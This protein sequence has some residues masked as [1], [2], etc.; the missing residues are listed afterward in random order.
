[1]A[2][3][4]KDTAQIQ[5]SEGTGAHGGLTDGH[6]CQGQNGDWWRGSVVLGEAAKGACGASHKEC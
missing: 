5:W 3:Q 2:F 4:A 1:M 6:C